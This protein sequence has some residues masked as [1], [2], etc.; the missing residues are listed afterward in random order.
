MEQKWPTPPA[1]RFTAQAE[2]K[3]PAPCA[4][5]CEA[6]AFEIELRM[7]RAA[8]RV[9]TEDATSLR[10][11]LEAARAI[12]IERGDMGYAAACDTF[13]TPNVDFSGSTPLYGGESAGK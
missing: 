6:N 12:F 1:E 3:H 5:F 4:R 8:N 9:L 2:G 7:L 10:K 11:G 13:L